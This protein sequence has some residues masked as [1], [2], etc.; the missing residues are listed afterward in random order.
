MLN[1]ILLHNANLIEAANIASLPME[2]SLLAACHAF[3]MLLPMIRYL[4]LLLGGRDLQ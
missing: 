1:A 3:E 2:Y 4:E